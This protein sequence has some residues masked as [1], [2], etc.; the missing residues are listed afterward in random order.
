M[1]TDY[2]SIVVVPAN[3]PTRNFS[4]LR[5]KR[6]AVNHF[7]S[8]SGFNALRALAAPLAE[9]GHF[10][11]EVIETG[12]HPA[13]LDLIAAGKAD[14]AAID[15]VT[16]ALLSH[17]RPTAVAH[18]RELCRSASAPSLPYV[19]SGRAGEA[20]LRQL[21]QGL[22]AAM[23]DPALADVRAALLLRGAQVLPEEDYSRITNMETVAH[24]RGYRALG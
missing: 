24:D 15:C 22:Q 12:G 19:T 18:V 5:G 13:S 3:A 4:K 14:V 20:R 9:A 7:H 21:R 6:A 11:D 17:Y 2:C 1:D 16:F 8:H 10:F 23:S